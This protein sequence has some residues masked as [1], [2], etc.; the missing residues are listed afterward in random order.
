MAPALADDCKRIFKGPLG[1][2]A[3]LSVLHM[4]EHGEHDRFWKDNI[5]NI[6]RC[7]QLDAVSAVSEAVDDELDDVADMIANSGEMYSEWRRQVTM[8][9]I[10]V[11]HVQLSMILS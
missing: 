4:L 11:L 6:L 10:R 8:E 3:N 1:K 5:D 9:A 7:E 2:A